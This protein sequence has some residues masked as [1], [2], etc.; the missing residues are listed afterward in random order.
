MKGLMKGLGIMLLAILLAIAAGYGNAQQSPEPGSKESVQQYKFPENQK[1][2]EYKFPVN[3][4]PQE[5]KFPESPKTEEYKIP[6]NQPGEKRN[7]TTAQRSERQGGTGG[8]GKNLQPEGEK[9]ILEAICR[10]PGC[11]STKERCLQG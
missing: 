11:N 8:A 3:P 7:V 4:N 1:P 9:G 5:Y 10:E 6:E 2:E